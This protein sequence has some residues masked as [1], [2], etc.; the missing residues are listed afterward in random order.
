MIFV[1]YVRN[2]DQACKTE[3]ICTKILC[4]FLNLNLVLLHIYSSYLN[5]T[6]GLIPKFMKNYVKFTELVYHIQRPQNESFSEYVLFKQICMPGICRLSHNYVYKNQLSMH[7]S[8]LHN[9]IASLGANTWKPSS[10]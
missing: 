2:C 6:S 4:H 10:I 9:C 3:H 8:K 7:I 5:K 1:M